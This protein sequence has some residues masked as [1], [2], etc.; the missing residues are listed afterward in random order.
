M[1]SDDCKNASRCARLGNDKQKRKALRKVNGNMNQVQYQSD[2]IN[3]IE[4]TCNC[5]VFKQKGYI[6]M[7]DIAP[8]HNSKSTGTFLECKGIS[9]LEWPE[10]L[11][12][13]NPIEN[14]WNIIKN[15]I[16]NQIL[17]KIEEMW[18]RVCDSWYGVAPN[19]LEE[20]YN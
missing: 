15:L 9:V 6:C 12:A 10:N 2:I 1:Y 18:K 17:C 7:H 8:C 5:A 13:M 3:D 19:V 14:V 16:G 20:P 4:I 11:P